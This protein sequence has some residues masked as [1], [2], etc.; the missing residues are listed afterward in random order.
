MPLTFR[1]RFHLFGP[2]WLNVGKKSFSLSTKV[3]PASRTV[4]TSGRR[5]TSV[6]LPGPLG[7]RKVTTAKHRGA[8]DGQPRH[9]GMTE[10]EREYEQTLAALQ[11]RKDA[12]LARRAARRRRRQG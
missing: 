6:N 8:A 1:K 2:F 5:T 9:R 11:A 3:G 10:E 4:S 12:A 7:Y